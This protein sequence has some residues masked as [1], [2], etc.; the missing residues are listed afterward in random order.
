MHALLILVFMWPLLSATKISECWPYYQSVWHR[1]G[2]ITLTL[3]GAI[4]WLGVLL[5]GMDAYLYY[6]TP[7]QRGASWLWT[8]L[9]CYAGTGIVRY[10]AFQESKREPPTIIFEHT[11]KYG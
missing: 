2:V 4:A 7:V 11:K 5:N 3:I 10:L 1:L 6:G 9:A 8:W